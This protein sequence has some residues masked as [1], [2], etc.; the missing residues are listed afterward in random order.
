MSSR[1]LVD[2][3]LSRWLSMRATVG[4]L[5]FISHTAPLYGASLLRGGVSTHVCFHGHFP[6][7]TAQHSPSFRRCFGLS[8]THT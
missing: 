8:E 7:A 4:V 3:S 6:R 1:L 5:S 2:G